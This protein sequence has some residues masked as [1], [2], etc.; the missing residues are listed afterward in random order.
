M[1]E[2]IIEIRITKG[3]FYRLYINGKEMPELY[4]RKQL[5]TAINYFT[6]IWENKDE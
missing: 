6:R 2:E 5:V 3:T 1:K 4:N